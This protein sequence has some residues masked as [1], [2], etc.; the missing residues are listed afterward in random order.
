MT[1]NHNI[2]N[3]TINQF[4]NKPLPNKPP[5]S[6]K[7]K[8][9]DFNISL[10]NFRTINYLDNTSINQ[11]QNTPISIFNMYPYEAESSPTNY[12]KSNSNANNLICLTNNNNSKNKTKNNNSLNSIISIFIIY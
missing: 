11:I 12:I 5:L 2:K 8:K 4:I 9:E 7:V 6:R 1:K 3:G 10:S